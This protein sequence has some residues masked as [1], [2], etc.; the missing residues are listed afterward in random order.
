MAFPI[1][2]ILNE[3]GQKMYAWASTKSVMDFDRG[4]E[5]GQTLQ[6]TLNDLFSSV[7]E[8]KSLIAAAVTE[9]GVE[10]AADSTFQEMAEN[11]QQI[12]T[13]IPLEVVDCYLGLSTTGILLYPTLTGGSSDKS[14]IE[15]L[16][17]NKM[18]YGNPSGNF[19]VVKDYPMVL[20]YEPSRSIA[21]MMD[22][23]ETIFGDVPSSNYR[24]YIVQITGPSPALQLHSG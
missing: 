13:E 21:N 23:K 9:K 7:S 14:S 18:E 16:H 15:D 22:M 4:G 5:N 17:Y 2:W 24:F 12:S 8:G 20:L 3:L 1:A 6:K 11:I 10:T 19:K